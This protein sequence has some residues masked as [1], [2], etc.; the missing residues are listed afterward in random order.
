MLI[1]TSCYNVCPLELG[2][3]ECDMCIDFI[4]HEI[5]YRLK[6]QVSPL[7][8]EYYIGLNQFKKMKN[9]LMT[10]AIL[11]NYNRDFDVTYV[12]SLRIYNLHVLSFSSTNKYHYQETHL[13]KSIMTGA[14]SGTGRTY[15][16]YQ[17]M[18]IPLRYK[19]FQFRC[20]H[21]DTRLSGDMLRIDPI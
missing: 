9:I 20:E 15:T 8:L 19:V 12:C 7:Y 1:K 21:M 2:R 14:T 13:H 6:V 17:N 5:P 16:S 10:L 18:L 11:F 3:H 4:R